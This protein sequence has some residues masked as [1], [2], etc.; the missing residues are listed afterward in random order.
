[1]KYFIIIIPFILIGCSDGEKKVKYK[2]M[3]ADPSYTEITPAKIKHSIKQTVD[4]VDPF[5][6]KLVEVQQIGD[7][8]MQQM[9]IDRKNSRKTPSGRK[10]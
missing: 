8:A 3:V 9:V 2:K 7:E 5:A 1:M 6:T 10:D 4:V